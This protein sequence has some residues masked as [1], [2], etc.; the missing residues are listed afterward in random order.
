MATGWSNAGHQRPRRNSLPENASVPPLRKHPRYQRPGQDDERDEKDGGWDDIDA[1]T[2][3]DVLDLPR[4][5][6]RLTLAEIYE[7][8]GLAPGEPTA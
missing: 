1:D 7:G 4:I 3:D 8:T 5:G 6:C 2:L